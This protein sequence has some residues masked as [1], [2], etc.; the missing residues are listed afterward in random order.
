MFG[1]LLLCCSNTSWQ[2]VLVLESL[3]ASLLNAATLVRNMHS[4]VDQRMGW[5]LCTWGKKSLK[6]SQ[7]MPNGSFCLFRLLSGGSD[8]WSP[9]KGD[10]LATTHFIC[11]TNWSLG[12]MC[13]KLHK[14]AQALHLLP[15]WSRTLRWQPKT[16]FLTFRVSF[17]SMMSDVYGWQAECLSHFLE[18]N[19]AG[20]SLNNKLQKQNFFS[21]VAPSSVKGHK[22]NKKPY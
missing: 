8:D 20:R 18:K 2:H 13:R 15:A 19:N 5:G 14:A 22:L 6:F 3:F 9:K 7:P 17:M 10:V 1:R 16:N 21:K 12:C 4:C 11:L